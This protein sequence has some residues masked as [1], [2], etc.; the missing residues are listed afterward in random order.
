VRCR[1]GKTGGKKFTWGRSATKS[2]KQGR[3]PSGRE[4]EINSDSPI[5]NYTM[6]LRL[7]RNNL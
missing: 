4:G 5:N 6:L 7:L 1:N 2:E 3:A